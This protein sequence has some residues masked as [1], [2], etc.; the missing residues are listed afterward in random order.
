M[1]NDFKWLPPIFDLTRTPAALLNDG[2]PVDA[3]HTPD[4]NK[5]LSRSLAFLPL[6][7][8][9]RKSIPHFSARPA[10][11]FIATSRSLPCPRPASIGSIARAAAARRE[12]RAASRPEGYRLTA[13][14]VRIDTE[15]S[16]RSSPPR[17]W[18]PPKPARAAAALRILRHTH[19]P[20]PPPFRGTP[21]NAERPCGIASLRFRPVGN[22][23][24]PTTRW[25]RRAALS[26]FA[27]DFFFSRFLYIKIA[28]RI[29]YAEL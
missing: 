11:P 18:Q 22:P 21:E 25:R 17:A 28:S 23:V 1:L 13:A 8:S 20:P 29:I 3:T 12:S 16:V 7:F 10:S 5:V 14:R 19:T 4:I 6:P 27:L 26:D 2:P 9:L 24:P 15:C